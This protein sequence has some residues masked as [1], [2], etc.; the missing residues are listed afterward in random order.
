MFLTNGETHVKCRW[1]CRTKLE[2]T[3]EEEARHPNLRKSSAQLTKDEQDVRAV[4]NFID[5]R[6]RRG[7]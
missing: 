3:A 4:L 1:L 7:R 5:E 2:P 6:L